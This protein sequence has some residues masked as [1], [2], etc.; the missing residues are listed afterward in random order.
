MNNSMPYIGI[1][2]MRASPQKRLT[3]KTVI[4]EGQEFHISSG[5][6]S[7]GGMRRQTRLR[8]LK[9]IDLAVQLELTVQDKAAVDNAFREHWESDKDTHRFAY[10]EDKVIPNLLIKHLITGGRAE[11]VAPVTLPCFHVDEYYEV[12]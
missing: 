7:D 12:D 4:E 6:D 11:L 10:Y 9:P 1:A 2:K 5:F 8:A 3:S